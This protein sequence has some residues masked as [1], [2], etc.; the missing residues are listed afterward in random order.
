MPME[1]FVLMLMVAALFG[2]LVDS[3]IESRY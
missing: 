2:M 1:T 3:V